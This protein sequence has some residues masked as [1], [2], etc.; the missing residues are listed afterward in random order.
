MNRD[1]YCILSATELSFPR[2]LHVTQQDDVSQT[3]TSYLLLV[4]NNV[5]FCCQMSATWER[6]LYRPRLGFWK[7]KNEM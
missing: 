1:L 6:H 2:M 3:Q 5:D 7:Y 4:L